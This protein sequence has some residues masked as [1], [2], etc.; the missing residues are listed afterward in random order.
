LYIQEE[1]WAAEAKI[2]QESQ[3]IEGS[4]CLDSED[5]EN[6]IDLIELWTAIGLYVKTKHVLLSDLSDT[7]VR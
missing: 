7:E 3:E 6:L 5:E 4:E 1:Y 2:L